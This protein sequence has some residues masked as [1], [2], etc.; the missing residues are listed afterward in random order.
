M[1]NGSEGLTR[2]D[3]MMAVAAAAAAG[4]AGGLPLGWTSAARAA[5][6]PTGK[7][8]KVLYFTKSQGFQHSVV[9]RPKDKPDELSF[10]E[11]L[12]VQWGKE[13]GFEVTPT[14]DGRVFTPEKIA[15]FDVLM[16]YTT[17]DL[18]KEGTDKTPPMPA[19]GKKVLLDAVAGGKGF[20]GL[21]CASDTFHS[22]KDG[23]SVDPY[24]KMVGGEFETHLKQQKSNLILTDKDFKPIPGL[25]AFTALHEEWYLLKNLNPEMHVLLVQDVNSMEDA[26]YKN[27]GNYPET[28]ARMHGKGRVFYSSMG[29]REDVWQN[30]YFQKILLGGLAWAAGNVDAEVKPNFKEACPD[31]MKR[32][33]KESTAGL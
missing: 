3:A 30:P 16:F 2:R 22:P 4:A 29:H 21:H 33:I 25:A 32:A 7:P 11:K 1:C 18:E 28:W 19:G 8:K 6:A 31:A 12:M 24:I 5:S 9:T 13:H 20:L 10:S 17:G 15:E 27:A 14:K 26:V 23:S